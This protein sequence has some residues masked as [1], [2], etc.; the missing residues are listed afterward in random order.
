[1]DPFSLSRLNQLRSFVATVEKANGGG[2]SAAAAI[3][4]SKREEIVHSIEI[5]QILVE[6]AGDSSVASTLVNAWLGSLH[7]LIQRHSVRRYLPD[8]Y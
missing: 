4:T 1:M 3:D 8:Y 6:P 7:K 2:D 5:N